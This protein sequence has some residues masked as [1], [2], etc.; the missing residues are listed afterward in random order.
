M[1]FVR[2][3]PAAYGFAD[4]TDYYVLET[5]VT[6][7]VYARYLADTGAAKGDD[8]VTTSLDARDAERQRTGWITM[9]TGT[10]RTPSTTAPWSGTA[11]VLPPA[12]G[13]SRCRW[14]TPGRPR[15]SARG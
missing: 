5:E 11:T 3:S 8:Q 7:E 15:T 1:R 4:R 14:S 9:S 10:P 6:N 13:S 2:V 12:P